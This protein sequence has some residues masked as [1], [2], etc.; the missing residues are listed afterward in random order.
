MANFVTAG[1]TFTQLDITQTARI[2][3]TYIPPLATQTAGGGSPGPTD[4][5]STASY[6][7]PNPTTPAFLSSYD[8]IQSYLTIHEMSRASYRY[9]YIGW[10]IVCLI[11]LICAFLHL[12][13]GR[14]GAF[15]AR[16]FKWALRRRTWRKQSTLRAIKKSPKTHRQPWV[17]PSNAQVLSL[18]SLFLVTALL[19]TV[20][21]DYIAPGT[22]VWDLTHNLT[23]R[24]LPGDVDLYL[25]ELGNLLPRDGAPIASTATT[26]PPEFTIQKAW[27]TAGGRT[28][29]IAYALF[30]LVVLFALKAP[31]FAIF[32]IPFTIQIHF[33]KLATIPYTI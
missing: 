5:T 27:W 21:P 4:A 7:N 19:C 29:I 16:W 17:L 10:L 6:H 22:A 23:R 32:A 11:V 26:R 20:G 2:G 30:P 33:D 1:I 3:A 14:G 31:P 8:W 28:G 24:H 12:T 18:V 25:N 9:A 15:G 13:G